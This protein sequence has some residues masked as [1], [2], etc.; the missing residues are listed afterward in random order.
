MRKAYHRGDYMVTIRKLRIDGTIEEQR[1]WATEFSLLIATLRPCP[2]T[3][4]S[5]PVGCSRCGKV[6]HGQARFCRCPGLL[7]AG[8]RLKGRE[9]MLW[10][11]EVWAALGYPQAEQQ[12]EFALKLP[13]NNLFVD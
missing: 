8:V 11:A 1:Q 2:D 7:N 10:W 5:K 6:F 9:E 13:V 12:L 3:D 4:Y